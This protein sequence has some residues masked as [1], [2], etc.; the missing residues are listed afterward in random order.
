MGKCVSDEDS[1]SSLSD[2]NIEDDRSYTSLYAMRITLVSSLVTVVCK[3]REYTY[4]R[5]CL[6]SIMCCI[7]VAETPCQK[8]GGSV[9][10]KFTIYINSE[11][12]HSSFDPLTTKFWGAQPPLI[13]KWG[14]SSPP[15]PPP[16]PGSLPLY[17][18]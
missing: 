14:G 15:A 9:F 12:L 7:S 6:C 8:W 1:G 5:H 2:A 11:M 10:M 4:R 3:S 13:T 18:Y 17:I 16:P